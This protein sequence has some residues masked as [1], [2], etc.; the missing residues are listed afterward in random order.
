MAFSA[1]SMELVVVTFTRHCHWNGWACNMFVIERLLLWNIYL[2]I[3]I[4]LFG[5]CWVNPK[6]VLFILTITRIP[7]RP[8]WTGTEEQCLF[9]FNLSSLATWSLSHN[10]PFF[11]FPYQWES[12]QKTSSLHFE[13]DP[14]AYCIKV[15]AASV[16]A[17]AQRGC[18]VH[19]APS[20]AALWTQS[21]FNFEVLW[22]FM[23][24][25]LP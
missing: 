16:L 23:Y 5:I 13:L 1:A 19:I 21:T 9:G 4:P 7:G 6:L 22:G 14:R 25:Y 2:P 11:Q 3:L 12:S 24:L 10:S 20:L 15:S 17:V 18:P 8:I